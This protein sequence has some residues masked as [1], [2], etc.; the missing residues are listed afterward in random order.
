MSYGSN[1]EV[2]QLLSRTFELV[3]KNAREF[4][5][6]VAVIGGLT[7]VGYLLNFT[8]I[9]SSAV[10]M[11]FLIDQS[12]S[13]T[14]AAFDLGLLVVSI[15]ANYLLLKRLLLSEREHSDHGNRFWAYLGMYILSVLAMIVGFLLLIIPGVI[16]LI[17]WSATSGYVI[18]EDCSVSEAFGKSWEA[19]SGSSWL[20]LAA[21]IVLLLLVFM[22]SALVA[23]V[24][25]ILGVTAGSAVSAL[26]EAASTALFL[27]FG[28]AVYLSVSDGNEEVREVFA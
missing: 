18:G 14:S 7:A 19:T 8:D 24:T 17:R 5:A 20:I 26:V 27:A 13:L 21:G 10:S 16:L 22:A 15:I 11:E 3:S 1:V 28:I 4:A 12:D 23:G 6:Y 9:S 25:G 2:G